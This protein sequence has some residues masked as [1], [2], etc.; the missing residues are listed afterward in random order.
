MGQI[1][2]GS[3]STYRVKLKSNGQTV[4]ATQ[5]QIAADETIP[6]GTWTPVITIST[7]NGTS[8]VQTYYIQVPVWM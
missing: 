2:S 6:A 4:T 7:Q 1:V 5:L 3:G 8:T